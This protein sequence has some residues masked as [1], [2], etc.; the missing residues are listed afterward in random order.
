M[1]VSNGNIICIISHSCKCIKDFISSP[2]IIIWNSMKSNSKSS[3]EYICINTTTKKLLKTC[4]ASFESP[5]T[6]ACFIPFAIFESYIFCIMMYHRLKYFDVIRRILPW[7]SLRVDLSMTP[8]QPVNPVNFLFFF[9]WIANCTIGQVQSISFR[10]NQTLKY[11][12]KIK[13]I[14]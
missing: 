7:S 4:I 12:S 6:R 8:T 3:L 2:I 11:L 1:Y 14:R 10:S 5:S 9:D 13:I